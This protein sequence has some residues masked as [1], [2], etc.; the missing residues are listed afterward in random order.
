MRQLLAWCARTVTDKQWKLGRENIMDSKAT[1]TATRIQ[2]ALIMRLSNGQ[3]NTSWYRRPV[4]LVIDWNGRV[5]L[6]FL[7]ALNLAAYATG[8]RYR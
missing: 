2:D 5:R 4:S 1:T 8:W 3:I 6:N 7:N